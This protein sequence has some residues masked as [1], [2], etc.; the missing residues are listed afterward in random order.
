MLTQVERPKVPHNKS[1][2]WPAYFV[3]VILNR[4]FVYLP[5]DHIRCCILES[6]ELS[7]AFVET[8][9]VE[10]WTH[11]VSRLSLN[12]EMN[13]YCVVHAV[14]EFVVTDNHPIVPLVPVKTL[15]LQ[16]LCL[17]VGS[18]HDVA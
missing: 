11:T 16:L 7:I 6:P 15:P 9:F 2:P 17:A 8:A 10:R 3:G 12:E 4:V 5:V 13:E 18:R 14:L 1:F